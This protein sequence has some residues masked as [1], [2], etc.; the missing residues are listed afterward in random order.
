M[1]QKIVEALIAKGSVFLAIDPTRGGVVGLPK[2]LAQKDHVV[3]QLGYDLAI[4]IPD[5]TFTPNAVYATLS[6]DG[7]PHFVEVPWRAVYSAWD[8][9]GTVVQWHDLPQAAKLAPVVEQPKPKSN[10]VSFADYKRRME[11][12]AG[13]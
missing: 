11:K 10:V 4:P 1:K 6:F 13:K 2:R 5:L 9:L 12:E 3:L 7:K 8:D